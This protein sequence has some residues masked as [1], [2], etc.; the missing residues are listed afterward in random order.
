MLLPTA[1]VPLIARHRLL[2]LSTCGDVLRANPRCA[3]ALYRRGLAL[4]AGGQL[5]AAAWDLKQAVR[6]Q[7]SNE[8]A[9]AAAERI[10]AAAAAKPSLR[11]QVG[12]LVG[13][14]GGDLSAMMEQ[15]MGGGGGGLASLL[16]GAPGGG[17]SGSD[18]LMGLL[19]SGS[20]S[21]SQADDAS[22]LE[23][24]LNSPLLAAGIG[25]KGGA[26]AL[27]WISRALTAQRTVKRIYRRL[28]VMHTHRVRCVPPAMANA[29]DSAPVSF[30]IRS[31][32]CPLSS[33]WLCYYRCF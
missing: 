11:K 20:A 21:S 3:S 19:G 14:D 29:L 31:H 13:S 4:E 18:A 9:V 33:G 28:K 6:L 25:G 32:T 12:P 24:L 5:D 22:P 16:G 7:P 1:Q 30:P 23:A 10:T 17:S 27:K 15:M 26:G 2:Q 8:R